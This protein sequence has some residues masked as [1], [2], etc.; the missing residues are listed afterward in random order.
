MNRRLGRLV[1]RS[2]HLLLRQM[3]VEVIGMVEVRVR[4]RGMNKVV[5]L[6]FFFLILNSLEAGT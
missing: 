6:L 5:S 4:I 3:G 1:V 2:R